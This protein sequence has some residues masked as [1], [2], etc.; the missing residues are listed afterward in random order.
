MLA[1]RQA[2]SCL[3]HEY[4]KVKK[5]ISKYTP[6]VFIAI[7]SVRPSLLFSGR[8]TPRLVAQCDIPLHPTDIESDLHIHIFMYAPVFS[9]ASFLLLLYEICFRLISAT[10]KQLDQYGLD[11]CS[12]LSPRCLILLSS[13]LL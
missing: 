11:K 3:L 13:Q 8:Y 5:N 12:S 10:R 4:L 1:S 6:L 2:I 7:Y 9:V